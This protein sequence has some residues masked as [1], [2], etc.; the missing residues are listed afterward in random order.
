[1]QAR[2][3]GETQRERLPEPAVHDELGRLAIAL[4]EM[5]DR[6]ERVLQSHR[7]FTADAS[8]EMRSPLSRMRTELEVTLDQPRDR[9][10]YEAVLRSA[11]EEVERLS[12]LTEELLALARLDADELPPTAASPVALLPLVHEE[13]QRVL[14]EAEKRDIR[15]QV[16]G[17][18]V[19][20]VRG[21][22]DALRLVVGNLLQNAV[23]FSP[24]KGKITVTVLAE[25]GDAVLAVSDMGPGLAPGEADR[26][27]DRFYRGSASSPDTPGVG[28][29]LAI[30]RAIVT[31]YGGQIAVTSEPGTGA[32][33]TVRL[34]LAAAPAA[35]S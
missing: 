29:G 1:M 16:K 11:L 33:F 7:R 31:R 3:I 25:T 26:I 19:H 12:R 35:H 10:E 15:C 8:H 9:E 30:V 27:F 20:A 2:R 23:K 14:P 28:L 34:P 6:I 4:N 18:A 17:S 24:S 21:S 22:P 13:L 5:L 32:T